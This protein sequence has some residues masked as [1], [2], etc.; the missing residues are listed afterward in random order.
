MKRGDDLIEIR[1]N[2][3]PPKYAK[4]DE[5]YIEN[6]KMI[7]WYIQ[8]IKMAVHQS[9]ISTMIKRIVQ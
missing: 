8:K 9:V 6:E 3:H 5:I 7:I 1:K 2:F 4:K